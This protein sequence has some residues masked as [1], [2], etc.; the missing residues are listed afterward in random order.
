MI[1]FNL[2]PDVK[3]EYVKAERVKRLTFLVAFIVTAVALSIFIILLFITKGVQRQ[4]VKNVDASIKKNTALLKGI[5]GVDKIL[6]VQNQLKT[7]KTLH[8]TKP[9]SSRLYGFLDQLTPAKAS[10]TSLDVDFI[11][12]N[13][14][15]NG[16]ADSLQTINQF[17]D[18]L[19]FTNYTIDNE[20]SKPA[21]KPVVLKTLTR[22]DKTASYNLSITFD[23]A[24]FDYNKKV[25]LVVPQDRITTRS[26]TEQ[27]NFS[28]DQSV[29]PSE[30]IR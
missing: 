15:I 12:S 19:K 18:T 1:Q 26:Y 23:K 6:T 11:T 16:T 7:V 27:P 17:A 5:G 20:P 28:N 13:I 2:L 14:N 21:F 24:L 4:Q 30:E 10:I 22:N 9:E 25:A 8:S 29:K 3:I